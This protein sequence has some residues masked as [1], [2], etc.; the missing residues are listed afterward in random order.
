[1]TQMV[2]KYILAL[3]RQMSGL[4]KSL[5]SF[6]GRHWMS[7]IAYETICCSG[8]LIFGR[9]KAFSKSGVM[10][11]RIEK[12]GLVA[13]RDISVGAKRILT[14]EQGVSI[15]EP[16]YQTLEYLQMFN[17]RLRRRRRPPSIPPRILPDQSTAML[18]HIQPGADAMHVYIAGGIVWS[19]S[20]AEDDLETL[21]GENVV[22][23]RGGHE[24][25]SATLRGCTAATLLSYGRPD[26]C[27]CVN[28]TPMGRSEVGRHLLRLSALKVR[29]GAAPT[30]PGNL[31]PF[32]DAHGRRHSPS[33]CLQMK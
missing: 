14:T 33:A 11:W 25:L 17:Q 9:V 10:P 19:S 24:P 7:K 20:H 27:A 22:D 30:W 26:G 2:Q 13:S 1:M 29:A 21:A 15:V 32:S 4:I 23:S 3:G 31:E 28:V 8:K 12:I 5:N 6:F 16:E 18:P